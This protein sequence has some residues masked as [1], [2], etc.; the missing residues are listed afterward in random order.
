[1]GTSTRRRIR[2]AGAA[3]AAALVA[4]VG[5][6]TSAGAAT[7]AVPGVIVS[8]FE[9]SGIH[10]VALALTTARSLTIACT[11]TSLTA[12]GVSVGIPCAAIGSLQLVGSPASD[13]FTVDGAALRPGFEP[14]ISIDLL[15]GNDA[16]TVTHA[17][18]DAWLSG[19]TGDDRLAV[20]R[21]TSAGHSHDRLYGG[22]GNDQL[23]NLGYRTGGEAPLDL[24]DAYE[25]GR[26]AVLL[27]GGAGSD[28]LTGS[29]TRPD[30]VAMETGDQVTLGTGPAD[31]H[32][33]LSQQ[34][35]IVAIHGNGSYG[36]KMTA[37]RAGKTWSFTFPTLTYQLDVATLGGPD[38]VTVDGK[39]IRTPLTLDVGT[40]A[41]VLTIRPWPG[42]T[43]TKVSGPAWN[44][45]GTVTQPGAKPITYAS[46]SAY[47]TVKV[48]P[49]P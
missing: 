26:H 14:S 31:V 25:T 46:G 39:S 17:T 24:T 29:S 2:S 41:D 36:T 13:T 8:D 35:D 6:P 22:T 16:A 32:L 33:A 23:S 43:W 11:A 20:V 12:N 34:T 10:D 40:G 3:L 7:A 4:T 19:G 37:T 9:Q 48:V 28:I 15:D 1:M 30:Q 38:Q 44:V 18:G 49:L 27:D 21:T 5:A 47:A 42:F 45:A